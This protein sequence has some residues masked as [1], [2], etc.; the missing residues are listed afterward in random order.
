MPEKKTL[1]TYKSISYKETF[2][3]KGQSGISFLW[4]RWSISTIIWKTKI[5]TRIEIDIDIQMD[6]GI[7]Q[8]ALK[9]KTFEEL[10]G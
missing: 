9:K 1:N 10:P 8:K 4:V 3:Y 6:T 7:D 5:F 2:S